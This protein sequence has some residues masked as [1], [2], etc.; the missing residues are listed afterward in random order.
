MEQETE[1]KINEFRNVAR[2][3]EDTALP[4]LASYSEIPIPLHS[5][6]LKEFPRP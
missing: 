1:Q 6:D 3:V 4:A 5:G 2:Y